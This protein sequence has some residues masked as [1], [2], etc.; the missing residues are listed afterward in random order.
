MPALEV[1]LYFNRRNTFISENEL[2]PTYSKGQEG[3]YMGYVNVPV[4]I[5]WMAGSAIAGDKYELM[6]DKI[7]L[8]KIPH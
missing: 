1:L 3:L 2:C 5:G 6:G 7:N 4:A 8:A